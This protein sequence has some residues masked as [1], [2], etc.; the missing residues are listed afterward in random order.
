MRTLGW[1]CWKSLRLWSE[2]I[3]QPARTRPPRECA[4]TELTVHTV[5]GPVPARSLG[6]TLPHEHVSASLW[7]N[8]TL[9]TAAAAAEPFGALPLTDAELD[10][11]I[12]AFQAQGGRTIVDVSLPG[13]G[14]D[15]ARLRQVSERT[16]IQI[17]MGCGWYRQP[18]YPAADMIDR[19]SA[20]ELAEILV[21]EV[22]EGVGDTGI[23]PGVIGEIGANN[24][25]VTAQEERVHR[26][27]A[28]ASLATGLAITTHS[29]WSPVGRLQLQIF[30]E[31]G[32]DPNRVVVGHCDSW[33][34]LDYLRDLVRTGAYVEF[35]GLG[36]W[37]INGSDRYEERI[38]DL[39]AT[40][41]DEG[42][43]ERILLAHDC[44]AAPQFLTYGGRGWEHLAKT[45]IPAL[46]ERGVGQ[47]AIDLITIENPSRIF[48]V[49]SA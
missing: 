10:A 36:Q 48:A 19:R 27:A 17:V 29:N 31:E 12:A 26:A 22:A 37:T 4:L 42:Y 24:K 49:Q 38:L 46:L 13:I 35:D 5:C 16:G 15:P 44:F 1:T 7:D 6:F 43:A 3:P 30:M 2:S 41:T 34:H 8:E 47:A 45:A 23:R 14:R 18:F 20:D 32:V 40:L 25:W 33:P 28:R 21:R 9:V 11:E 39:I